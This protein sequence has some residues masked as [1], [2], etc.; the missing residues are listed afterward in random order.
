MHKIRVTGSYCNTEVASKPSHK[1]TTVPKMNLQGEFWNSQ[2][3]TKA[4]SCQ[5][6]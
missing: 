2:K 1:L 3:N 5:K 4:L 6:L